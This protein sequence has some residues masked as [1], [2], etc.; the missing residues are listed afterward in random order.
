MR[1]RTIGRPFT[2]AACL[3]FAVATV[4]GAFAQ[5]AGAGQGRAAG[6]AGQGRAAGARADFVQRARHQRLAGSDLSMDED[7][8][9]HRRHSQH[10]PPETLQRGTASDQDAGGFDEL[11]PW[12]GSWPDSNGVELG[13]ANGTPN[14]AN[15]SPASARLDGAG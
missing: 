8:I 9:V 4:S 10:L 15:R 14:G 13:H 7:G 3:T 5:D 6:P 12:C 1:I 2:L 11:A